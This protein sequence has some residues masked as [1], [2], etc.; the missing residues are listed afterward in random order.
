MAHFGVTEQSHGGGVKSAKKEN[1]RS[2]HLV[3]VDEIQF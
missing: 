3:G 2:R 1:H